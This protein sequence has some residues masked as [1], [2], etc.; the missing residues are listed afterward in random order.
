MK[1]LL[2]AAALALVLGTGGPA[3]AALPVF[4]AANLSELLAQ[5]ATLAEQL[6]ALQ[7]Q[8]ETLRQQYATITNM[9]HEMRGITGHALMLPEPVASLHDFLP[10][11]GLDPDALLAGPLAGVAN[12]L[13]E[14]NELYSTAELFGGTHLSGAARQYQER[15]DFVY[16]YMALAQEAYQ[17]ITARRATLEAFADAAG[18]A[19]TQKAVLDLNTRIAA[20]NAL[21]LN[22]L[23]QLQALQLMATVQDQSIAHNDRGM[24]AK[25]TSG[26]GDLDFGP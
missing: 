3:R 15:S 20:E 19:S 8:L 7:Q 17:G 4:D 6:S 14:A 11:A 2:F 12:T 5:A 21:L 22:D 25:R 13:R 1:A 10:A 9:Y 23:A 16:A 24:H 18:S 26:V